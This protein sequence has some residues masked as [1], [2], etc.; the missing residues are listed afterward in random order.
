MK[1]SIKNKK[2]T[3]LPNG[4]Y[5]ELD[6]KHFYSDSYDKFLTFNERCLFFQNIEGEYWIALK[7]ICEALNIDW[8]NQFKNLKSDEILAGVLAKQPMQDNSNRVKNMVALPEKFV[9]GWLFSIRS[10]SSLLTRYK[11][12]CYEL[13]FDHFRNTIT[14]RRQVLSEKEKLV[15]RKKELQ[16]RL[17]N[18]PY[19][20]ELL[21]IEGKER[22]ASKVLKELDQ[23]LIIDQ[24]QLFE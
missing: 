13:L 23:G 10:K 3:K 14:T 22:K 4:F 12:M 16:E 5:S 6:D 20:N 8:K 11:K 15:T 9:Y 19:F 18:N 24:T 1:N 2:L 7:P 17:S 21:E